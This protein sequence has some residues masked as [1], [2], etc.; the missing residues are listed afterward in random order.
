MDPMSKILLE[1]AHE[2]GK[3]DAKMGE[4]NW[5]S[6]CARELDD[7]TY[8]QIYGIPSEQMAKRA[9]DVAA[10]AG[11]LTWT[12]IAIEELAEV[13]EAPSEA[14]RRAELIQLAAVCVAWIEAIDRRGAK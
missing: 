13:V 7:S 10:T 11:D 6:V 2:R 9:Y 1:V 5:P 14:H 3:Q 12:D 4:Q 8:A